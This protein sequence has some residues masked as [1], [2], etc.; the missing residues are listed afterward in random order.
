MNILHTVESYSPTICGMQE[1]VQQISERLSR[2]GHDVTVAT[3]FHPDRKQLTINGVAIKQFHIRGNAVREIKGEEN[4]IQRYIDLLCNSKFDIVTNFA[5]QQWATDLALPILNQIR[6]K[7]VFVPTGFSGLYYP[8]YKKYF[9]KMKQWM[10]QYDMN[11]FLSNDYR[12]IDFAR[13]NGVKKR[14]LIPNGASEEEFLSKNSIDIRKKLHIP[15]NHSLILHVG[16]HTGSKGHRELLTIFA[17]AKISNATLLIIGN[18][19][20]NGC[21]NACMLK[22]IAYNL[23]PK[24]LFDTNKIL[25]AS[26]NRPETVSAYHQADV[27]LFPSNIECSPI[28]LFEA[29]ASKTPFLSTNVGNAK[30]IIT[31]SNS[32]ILLPTTKNTN[33]YSFAD[34]DTSA[35]MLKHILASTDKRRTMA[36]NGYN[37]W[38]KRFTWDKIAKQYEKVYQNIIA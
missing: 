9:I 1:V 38:K 25:L 21:T 27:F 6:A 12:D 10:K 17:K 18:K 19:T 26:M 34:I 28:V 32:G 3:S 30:E 2:L 24:R 36:E 8:Q 15:S 11:V 29:M 35:H 7:K 31:W 14:I 23:S 37:A 13:K 20:T 22:S 33:G 4:E 5:A 16:S